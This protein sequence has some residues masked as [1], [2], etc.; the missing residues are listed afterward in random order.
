MTPLS[1][2]KTCALFSLSALCLSSVPASAQNAPAANAPLSFSGSVRVRQEV[3][4]WFKPAAS[5]GGFDNAY[6]FTGGT[7]RYGV[8]YD[9]ARF[10]ARGELQ[11]PF[12]FGL[13]KNA[14]APA[15]QGALGLGANYR[16]FNGAQN[17][18]VSETGLSSPQGHRREGQRPSH[19][20][21]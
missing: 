14:L 12:L 1:T 16:L 11:A 18:S 15:P 3:W 19:R 17:G 13:P 9:T 2:G 4:D 10:E 8:T 7:L 6:T 5:V 20:A 21:V